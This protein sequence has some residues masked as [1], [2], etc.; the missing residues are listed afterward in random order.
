MVG[1]QTAELPLNWNVP[2]SCVPPIRSFELFE[3]TERLW[4]CSVERP[5]LIGTSWFGTRESIDL[6]KAVPAASSPRESHFDE[7][8][9][10]C[11]SERTTPPSEPVM[12]VSGCPGS[13]TIA[14]WSGW[15]A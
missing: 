5:L 7:T 12:N 2:L 13:V 4:N 14:C 8:S 6:Q 10:Y 15:L 9:A 11:P 3:L 1:G